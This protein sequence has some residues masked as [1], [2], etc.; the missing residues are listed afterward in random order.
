MLVP[1]E[2]EKD[3]MY[4][5]QIFE[6]ISFFFDGESGERDEFRLADDEVKVILNDYLAAYDHK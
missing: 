4:A 2:E 5:K 3:F 6:L 1:R